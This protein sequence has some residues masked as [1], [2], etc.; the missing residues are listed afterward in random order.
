MAQQDIN[1]YFLL[2]L[3]LAFAGYAIKI[4]RNLFSPYSYFH[5]ANRKEIVISLTAANLTLGTGLVYYVTGAHHSGIM[6]FIIPLMTWFGYFL[7]S[8]FLKYINETAK[9]GKNLFAS[10]SFQVE[11]ETGK[12]TLFGYGVSIILI[13]V[14]TLA[15]AFEI[16]ASSKVISPFF[17]NNPKP[18]SEAVLSFTIFFVVVF[19]SLIGGLRAVIRTD[20]LQ[21]AI[22]NVFLP[23]LILTSLWNTSKS[24]S[25]IENI[26]LSLR[27]D[28]NIIVSILIASIA[29]IAT[30]F[31]S[32]LN[33]S[34]ISHVKVT[35]QAIVLKKVGIKVGI[36]LSA[37]AILG[38]ISPTNPAGDAWKGLM[39]PYM[40]STTG[41]NI[42]S[43]LICF[44]LIAGMVCIILTT[45]DSL[46][47]SITMIYYD[48]ILGRDSTSFVENVKELKSIRILGLLAFC[49]CFIMLS[50][51]NYQKPNIFYFLLYISGGVITLAPLI[52][53]AGYLSFKKIFLK[54]FTPI[55][56]VI[57]FSLFIFS[58]L[59]GLWALSNKQVIIPYIGLISFLVSGIYSIVIIKL[60]KKR[61]MR[62]NYAR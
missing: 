54:I 14:F 15:L 49:L 44:M 13:F 10:L 31:Y 55:V 9:G 47:I 33:W 36:F 51:L 43:Y 61:Y 22:V 19:Y 42:S 26:S 48:N 34:Y 4:A 62:G 20:R 58:S 56:L 8:K 25:V 46:V 1:F 24:S 5:E 28:I 23:I 40:A 30:Q 7:L 6:W 12:K 27:F 53:T 50:F 16:Y 57:Y 52:F 35:E 2:L 41:N 11:E 32:L 21:M 18:L 39:L 38:I 60:S 37:F 17:F 59:V 29:A 3:L 45:I